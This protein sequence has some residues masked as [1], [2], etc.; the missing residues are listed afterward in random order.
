MSYEQIKAHLKQ[1][2]LQQYE[3]EEAGDFTAAA[4]NDMASLTEKLKRVCNVYQGIKPILQAVVNF[5]FLPAAIRNGLKT[6]MNVMNAIC[7]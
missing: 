6:F 3:R 7:P 2:D 5:P 1:A 4:P